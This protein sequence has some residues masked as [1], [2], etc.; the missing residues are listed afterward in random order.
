L[1]VYVHEQGVGE[2]EGQECEGEDKERN[3]KA[4]NSKRCSHNNVIEVNNRKC[5][6]HC[7]ENE[8]DKEENVERDGDGHG[9]NTKFL[10]SN[11]Y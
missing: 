10:I 2:I 4:H 8:I 9:E 1:P 5:Q 7:Y 11:F 3:S 6:K